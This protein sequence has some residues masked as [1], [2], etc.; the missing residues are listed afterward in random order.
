M[1]PMGHKTVHKAYTG[2]IIKATNPAGFEHN[3]LMYKYHR[4][5]YCTRCGKTIKE[6][7]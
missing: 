1:L 3:M 5:N 2:Q 4:T 6:G 7:E